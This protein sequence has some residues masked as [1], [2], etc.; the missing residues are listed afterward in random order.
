MPKFEFV[1]GKMKAI[2]DET[3]PKDMKQKMGK[4]QTYLTMSKP[5]LIKLVE[6]LI[7]KRGE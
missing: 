5:N 3:N 2:Y 4:E 6:L 7:K 1:E